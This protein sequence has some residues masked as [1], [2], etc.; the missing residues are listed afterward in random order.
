[1]FT[2]S[3]IREKVFKTGIGYDRKDVE[4]FLNELASDYEALQQENLD[5]QK[6]FKDLTDSISYYKS[7]EKT[8]QKALFLAEKTAQ[9]TKASALREAELIEREATIKAKNII[10]NSNYE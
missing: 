5:S 10:A 8:L 2:P 3:E 7:I 4:Q 9:E 6:K 1:M